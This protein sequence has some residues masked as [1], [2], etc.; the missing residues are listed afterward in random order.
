[1]EPG[2]PYYAASLSFLKSLMVGLKL[3]T[4]ELYRSM[5]DGLL[6]EKD[7]FCVTKVR[8]RSS[9]IGLRPPGLRL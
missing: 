3:V 2:F 4:K 5:S 7:T 8:N 1:M 9:Q 6:E